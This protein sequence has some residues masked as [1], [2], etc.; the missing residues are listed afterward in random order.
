MLTS[1]ARVETGHASK[2][3]LQ[4]C[5][6]ITHRRGHLTT[7]RIRHM[8]M[9]RQDMDSENTAEVAA[10]AAKT[11]V[12]WT[13]SRGLIKFGWGAS[14]EILAENDALILHA[15]AED[16]AGL[17]RAMQ[18]LARNLERFGHRDGLHLTWTPPIP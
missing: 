15:E 14:C 2:Y 9:A 12:E 1:D 3:L 17:N 8:I 5:R 10:L 6:H 4:L 13:T 11:E 7:H 16:A 18:V